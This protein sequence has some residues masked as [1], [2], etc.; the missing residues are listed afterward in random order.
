MGVMGYMINYKRNIANGMSKADALEAFNNY[1]ATQQSRRGTDKIPLQFSNNGLVR[2]FTMFG[3]TLFL[4]MNKVMSSATNLSR[5]IA[6]GKRPRKQDI[7]AFYLNLAIANVLFVGVSNMMMF[8]KGDDEDREAALDKMRDAMLGLNL[9]YQIPYAGAMF[10]SLDHGEGLEALVTG[11]EYKKKRKMVDDVVNPFTSIS[12]KVNRLMKEEG[13]TGVLRP[14][15]E[16]VM[17]VQLDPFIGMFNKAMK[18]E[19]LLEFDE[20]MYDILGISKSYRPE[21]GKK[22]KYEGIMPV[23]GIKTK[24][25]LK[26]YDPDLYEMKYGEQDRIRKQQKEE[27]AR[28]LESMGYKEVG[29]KLYPID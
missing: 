2:G 29:G 4:Q 14:I 7:R 10:E 25:D 26:R 19:D 15:A 21:G 24:S 3:S 17:G 23:G 1:N 22:G 11:K 18:P 20:N 27:R 16:L 9:L 13:W 28:I 5:S 12:F 6:D 8:I